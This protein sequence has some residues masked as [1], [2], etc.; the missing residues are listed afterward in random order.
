LLDLEKMLRRVIG[1]DIELVISL[2]EGL[3]R[4]KTDPGQIEQV[5][6]NLAVNARDAMPGGG[7]LII[8][9]TNVELDEE[10]ARTHAT[11]KAGPYV[12]LSVTDTGTGMTHEVKR[13]IFEPFYTTKEIGKGTGLGLST[14]YGIVKQ[15]GGNIWVYSELG[16]GTVFKIYL[17][18][19]D[20][21]AE[22][23]AGEKMEMEE[24]LQGS[25][26]ILLVEDEGEVRRLALEFLRKQG[27]IVLEAQHGREALLICKNHQGSID[28][29]L[30][31]MIMPGMGGWE[32][33]KHLELLKPQT[34]VLYMSGYTDD[35]MVRN[36]SLT[37]G[38]HFIQKPFSMVSLARKIRDILDKESTPGS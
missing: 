38:F 18:R 26:T 17:P 4:M 2:G 36:G 25:E 23:L 13:H 14:V 15:S 33:A 20:A 19:V 8:E 28:L 35:A 24:T 6:L 31:D 3:G 21:Q 29:M 1:E 34:K 5:I 10:Y 22:A 12:R 37:K 27:Y 32:L 9:T 30:T 11:V 7:R 16:H